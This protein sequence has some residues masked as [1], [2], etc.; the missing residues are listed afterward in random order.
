MRAALVDLNTGVVSN[1]IELGEDFVPPEGHIAVPS[2]TAS[3]GDTYVDGA[4]A[5]AGA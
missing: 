2:D 4:F 5:P 3:I 1:V